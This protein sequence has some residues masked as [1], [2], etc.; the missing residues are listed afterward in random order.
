MSQTEK[1]KEYLRSLIRELC[2]MPKETGWVEFKQNWDDADDIGQ[3][4]SALSN[5]AALHHRSKAYVVWGIKDETHEIVGT[6]FNPA[7][8]KKGNEELENW[9]LR[10]LTPRIDF[11]FYMVDVNDKR[12]V[13][14]EID[15]ASHNPVSFSGVEYIR[16]GSYKKKLKEHSEKE[17]ALWRV[18]DN[19]PFEELVATENLSEMEVLQLIDYPAY[20]DLMGIPLPDNRRGIIDRL[21][22]ED[23]IAHTDNG[24]WNISNLGAVLF[25][26]NLEQ[27]KGIKRKAVRVILYKDRTR[28]ETIRE[29]LGAKGYANGFEG[30]IQFINSLL[31][32]NEVLGTALRKDVPMYPEIAVRE[33]VA[34]AIVHQDFN[35]TGT[36]P[37]IEIFSDRMEITNPGIPLV[38]PERFLDSPPISRNEV[39]ASLLRRMGICEERG[40]G[41]EKVVQATEDY[42]LPAPLFTKTDKHTRAILFAAKSYND[43]STEDKIRA[44]FLHASLKYKQHEFM[45]NTSLRERFKVEKQNSATVSRVIKQTV[46]AGLIKVVDEEVGTKGRKYVPH[47]A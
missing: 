22:K 35:V 43:M 4:I 3:Y 47:W 44:C 42:Q 28:Q 5:T 18:F 16:V 12:V 30:L 29:Q 26:K 41:I 33:L 14:L 21:Q 38:D 9:L 39:M 7:S 10:L 20:F 27:F 25:A 37:M 15:R 1:Q 6:D 46:D 8:A 40:S 17:R 31:P 19:T 45:T 24:A 2:A 34:N 32:R 11:V 13:I 36:G 23:V